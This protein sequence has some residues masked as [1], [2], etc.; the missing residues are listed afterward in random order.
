[1]VDLQD[2]LREGGTTVSLVKSRAILTNSKNRDMKVDLETIVIDERLFAK[3]SKSILGDI[4]FGTDF[5]TFEIQVPTGLIDELKTFMLMNLELTEEVFLVTRVHCIRLLRLC[6]FDNSKIESDSACWC[7]ILAWHSFHSKHQTLNPYNNLPYNIVNLDFK[8]IPNFYD[9]TSL[10]CLPSIRYRKV[11]I[12]SDLYR[13]D[14]DVWV[15]RKWLEWWLWIK[16][17]IRQTMSRT[18]AKLYRYILRRQIP[19]DLEAFKKYLKNSWAYPMKK[20][21]CKKD[22]IHEP[23]FK[24]PNFIPEPRFLVEKIDYKQKNTEFPFSYNCKTSW[25]ANFC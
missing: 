9:E 5:K 3:Y 18:D 25:T 23:E 15:K 19:I 7:P 20:D 6:Q 14:M 8:K 4:I 2:K 1:V 17:F 12:N 24:M 21:V 13:D 16:A 22:I 10:W 11:G